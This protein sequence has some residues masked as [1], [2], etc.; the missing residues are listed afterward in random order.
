MFNRL[1]SSC[2]YIKKH[3][4]EDFRDNTYHSIGV[5]TSVISLVTTIIS[6]LTG[7]ILYYV[8]EAGNKDSM[9]TNIKNDGLLLGFTE[10]FEAGSVTYMREG[11]LMI[12]VLALAFVQIVMSV[13]SKKNAEAKAIK[14]TKAMFNSLLL[15]LA[16]WAV[17][18]LAMIIIENVLSILQGLLL[19]IVIHF[20]VYIITDADYSTSSS[21][22]SSHSH[23]G[24]SIGSH[25]GGSHD[26]AKE[27]EMKE[28]QKREKKINQ[29]EDELKEKKIALAAYN[30]GETA[31][32]LGVDPKSM[33]IK[34]Q[35]IESKIENLK[36]S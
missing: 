3:L 27:R 13:L 14:I 24:F 11:L 10:S 8:Q 35:D 34:I 20:V 23:S 32:Y 25:S 30:R 12:L 2:N 1:R 29:L 18:P 7:I 26:P 21:G 16:Q 33:S 17:M 9:W 5:A 19:I 6:G 31:N 4:T 22:A 15:V 36:N 28:R